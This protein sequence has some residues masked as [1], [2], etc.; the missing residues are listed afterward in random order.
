M[1]ELTTQPK[2]PM[3]ADQANRCLLSFQQCLLLAANIHP[4]E[5]SLVEDQFAR[6]S[7][8][9]VST[10]VF[11]PNRASMDHR[12]RRA[13]EVQ[14]VVTGLLELLNLHVQSC[15]E[16]LRT[17]GQVLLDDNLPTTDG[18]LKKILGDIASE[19]SRLNKLSNV[20]RR[21]GKE[22]QNLRANEFSL[23]D[24]CGYDTASLLLS[25]FQHHIRDRF[26]DIMDTIQ[27][28]L[29]HAMVLRRKRILYK[30]SRQPKEPSKIDRV[31]SRAPISLPEAKE[32]TPSTKSFLSV[33]ITAPITQSRVAQSQIRSATTLAPEKFELAN[34]APSLVA[35]SKTVALGNHESLSFPPSPGVGLRLKYERMKENRWAEYEAHL[36]SIPGY[37]AFM[38]NDIDDIIASENFS[39][40]KEEILISQA[41]LER[42]LK[43]DLHAIGEV[44]CPYCLDALPAIYVFDELQW[45]THIKSDLDPYVCLFEKCDRPDEIYS[46]YEEWLQHM[47]DHY[48]LWRCS[49][50]RQEP[51]STQEEYL[52]HMREAHKTKLSDT[53]LRVLANRNARK[54]GKIFESCPL[55]GEA[56]LEGR[57]LDD[58]IVG[59]L[60]C[61]ALKSLPSYE[62]RLPEDLRDENNSIFTSNG[63]GG[64]TIKG[65]T[66]SEMSEG[67]SEIDWHHPSTDDTQSCMPPHEETESAEIGD[68]P[69]PI[70]WEFVTETCKSFA[71]LVD[72]SLIQSMLK[73]KR[74]EADVTDILTMEE[75]ELNPPRTSLLIE[76]KS[77]LGLVND[78]LL[79]CA[80]DACTRYQFP[81]PLAEGMRPIKG[82]RGREWAEWVHFLKRLAAKRRIPAR[83]FRNEQVGD[84]ITI[85]ENSLD[86]QI[87]RHQSPPSQNDRSM[88]RLITLGFEVAKIL[89]DAPAM[90]SLQEL[91]F[92]TKRQIEERSA[93]TVLPQYITFRPQPDESDGIT[94][95]ESLMLMYTCHL[96]HDV[97]IY[98][99]TPSCINCSHRPCSNCSTHY[100]NLME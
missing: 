29:A 3:V 22:T 81:I 56:N 27:E 31:A 54:Q 91:K 17:F 37:R 47:H 80:Y 15:S 46:H 55:C 75:L 49:T 94:R 26:P 73:R 67:G 57:P 7:A 48:C 63:R 60:R 58:H 69:H 24:E 28:R 66:V 83:A 2:Q 33:D 70:D 39:H 92:S 21:A 11:A 14:N 71:N 18:R 25:Q 16:Y 8:W 35:T 72:D 68:T 100:A 43:D 74:I 6:F 44:T 85:L 5:Y 53:K 89:E 41:K 61:L 79:Q 78:R 9:T 93:S 96:C 4:R 51:F 30:R 76:Q 32:A 45:Q 62:E 12:L 10:G 52:V 99:T 19:I 84:L 13:P 34:S 50:H 88:L 64:S 1:S 98:D 87:A 95:V 77:I 82:P 40:L 97:W 42:A 86:I 65:Y 38:T 36:E 23:Q 90:K 59:H 20:I